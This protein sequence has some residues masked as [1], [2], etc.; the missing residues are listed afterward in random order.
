MVYVRRAARA[1][2]EWNEKP[3]ARTFPAAHHEVGHHEFGERVRKAL[4]E[5][6]IVDA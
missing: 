3:R 2:Y 4:A 1:T 5:L 6:P